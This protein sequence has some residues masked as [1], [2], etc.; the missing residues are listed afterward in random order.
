MTTTSII[1]ARANSRATTD[2]AIEAVSREASSGSMVGEGES[3]D[4]GVDVRVC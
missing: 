2:M 3:D 1:I 4:S